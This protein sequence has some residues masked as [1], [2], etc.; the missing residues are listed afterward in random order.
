MMKIIEII[1]KAKIACVAYCMNASMSPIW[2]VPSSIWWAP[3]QTTAIE[4]EVEDEQHHRLHNGGQPIDD[5]VGVGQLAV[6]ALEFHLL[7]VLPVE[8]PN[9]PQTG[10][11][12]AGDQI[13]PV[14]EPLQPSETRD[15]APEEGGDDH[16]ENADRDGH[17]PGHRW[18][19]TVGLDDGA[20]SH[21]GRHQCQSEQ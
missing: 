16:E 7:V 19:E 21:K 18:R 10:Q 14:D 1:R 6:R 5:E 20:D 15:R 4:V 12:L 8:R 11:T 13:E 3:T 9:H 2:S 17:D